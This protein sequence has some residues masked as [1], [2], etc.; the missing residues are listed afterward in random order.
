LS[1][2]VNT[3]TE[4]TERWHVRFRAAQRDLIDACGGIERVAELTSYGKS[5]VGRW[6][7]PGDRDEMPRPVILTLEAD[8]GRPLITRLMNEFNGLTL[9]EKGAGSEAVA[10]LETLAASLVE[11]SGRFVVETIRARGDGVVTPS[12]ADQLRAIQAQV[13]RLNDQ[14]ADALAGIRSGG[15]G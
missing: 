8:C 6:R 7:S 9:A 4:W 15:Q 2:E 1:L 5:T 11:Q 14:I 12:E 13:G 10:G 3:M